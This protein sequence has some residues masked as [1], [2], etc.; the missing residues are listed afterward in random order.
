MSGNFREGS[1]FYDE[2]KGVWRVNGPVAKYQWFID[3]LCLK[4]G[5]DKIRVA[6]PEDCGRVQKVAIYYVEGT[7]E[8]GF[9]I[10]LFDINMGFDINEY[11]KDVCKTL[12]LPDRVPFVREREPIP[13]W[14][15]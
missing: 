4:Y 8:Y 1:L 11:V 6:A 5:Q 14:R 13:N 7:K 2:Q 12:E 9:A 15:I 3:L 10:P